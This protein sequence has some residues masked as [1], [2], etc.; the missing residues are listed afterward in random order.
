MEC[1]RGLPSPFPRLR[2]PTTS[3]SAC[4]SSFSCR[5]RP[6][7]AAISGW[8]PRV[9]G[10]ARCSASSASS[11]TYA[12]LTAAGSRLLGRRT[13]TERKP[14]SKTRGLRARG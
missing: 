5:Q 11:R 1:E 13:P 9:A 4:G 7:A 10:S 8:L 12:P 3:S 6:T 2:A 14:A